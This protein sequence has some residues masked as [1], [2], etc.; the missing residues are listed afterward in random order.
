MR[1]DKIIAR[2]R[3]VDLRSLTLEAAL[4]ELLSLIHI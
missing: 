4:G 1:L 2:S 3:I